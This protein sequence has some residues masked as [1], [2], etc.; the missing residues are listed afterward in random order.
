MPLSSYVLDNGLLVI[1]TQADKLHICSAEPATYSDVLSLTLGNKNFGVGAV[2]GV[3]ASYGAGQRVTVNPVNDGVETAAGT[4]ISWAVVDSANSRLHAAGPLGTSMALGGSSVWKTPAFNINMPTRAGLDTA[5]V[6]WINA[7]AASGGQVS[8]S[9]QS[10]VNN[11]VVGL[12][13]DGVW[14]KFDRL[15]ML[16]RQRKTTVS[17]VA[18]DLLDKNLPRWKVERAS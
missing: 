4:A 5:T 11:L 16:A 13:I 10:V 6:A 7:V 9:R 3:P 18:N 17:A 14:N 8:V 15:W 2:T 1:D 12:K